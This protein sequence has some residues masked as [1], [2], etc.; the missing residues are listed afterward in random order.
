MGSSDRTAV[1][2][3]SPPSTARPAARLFDNRFCFRLIGV[4]WSAR[5]IRMSFG[6]RGASDPMSTNEALVYETAVHY[7]SRDR[8]GEVITTRRWW[9]NLAFRKLFAVPSV[10]SHRPLMG[11]VGTL[12]MR[13]GVS[14]A[15]HSTSEAADE[16]PTAAGLTHLMPAGT[17]QLSSVRPAT[18]AE[19]LLYSATSNENLPTNCSGTTATGT[20]RLP[21][22][23][24]LRHVRR[25]DPPRRHPDR[26][27]H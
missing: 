6:H 1:G 10:V 14:P 27:G 21:R 25:P 5:A 23:R 19:R 9:R 12:T 18:V 17:F 7:P 11:P 3:E 22:T 2:N 4:D 15:W 20:H 26:R 13:G 8:H 24:T 16:S